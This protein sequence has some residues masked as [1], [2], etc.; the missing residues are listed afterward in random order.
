MFARQEGTGLDYSGWG[1][2]VWVRGVADLVW[3]RV[4]DGSSAVGVLYIFYPD[5][6]LAS[7]DLKGVNVYRRQEGVGHGPAPW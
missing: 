4:N 5:G 6:Y 2:R 7:D 3:I 1:G